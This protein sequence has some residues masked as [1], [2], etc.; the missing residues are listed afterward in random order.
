[1]RRM[2]I[3]KSFSKMTGL[4]LLETMFAIAIGAL[5]LIGAV[6]FYMSTKQ[7]ANTNKAVGDMNAIVSAIQNY[8]AGGNPLGGIT[9][10]SDLQSGGYLPNPL[11]DPWGQQYTIVVASSGSVTA[12]VTIT[13]P[14]IDMG[15]NNCN[16]IKQSVVTGSG[17][18]KDASK[19]GS[20]AFTYNL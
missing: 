4:T 2:L 15:D 14:G 3:K 5:V 10:L 12:S 16:A 7:N 17:A 1:M 18:A 8:T 13:I 9:D 20:C 11:N 6:I 19:S